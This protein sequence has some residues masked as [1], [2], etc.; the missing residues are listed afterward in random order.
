MKDTKNT[1]K[2]LVQQMA[3]QNL[4]ISQYNCIITSQVSTYFFVSDKII[5]NRDN[6]R[7]KCL[8][9]NVFLVIFDTCDVVYNWSISL[10]PLTELDNLFE[11]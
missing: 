4:Y 1:K 9:Y 2:I 3:T 6:F 11:E 7:M 8:S 5:N 10:L